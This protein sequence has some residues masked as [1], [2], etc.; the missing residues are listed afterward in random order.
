MIFSEIQSLDIECPTYETYSVEWNEFVTESELSISADNIL[1]E[2]QSPK[3]NFTRKVVSHAMQFNQSYRCIEKTAELIN[4]TP[5]AQIRVPTSIYKVKKHTPSKLEPQYYIY[6]GICK[7]YLPTTARSVACDSC[8]QIVKRSTSKYFIYFPLRT[9]L[10]K[11][12]HDHFD[13][14]IA[15]EKIFSE[16]N[17]MIRD[18][19]DC[20]VYKQARAAHPNCII[21]PIAGNTDGPKIFKSRIGSI[22]PLQIAQCFLPPNIRYVSEN[23]ILAAIHKGKK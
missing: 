22:W 15:Y 7:S 8:A 11:S 23:N 9:Q 5:G 16:E 20:S 4:S 12:I 1:I 14:I 6:C 13:K 2:K 3:T 17:D 19:H 21:L 10:L 18:L